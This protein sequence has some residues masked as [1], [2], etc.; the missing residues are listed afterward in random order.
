MADDYKSFYDKTGEGPRQNA[1]RAGRL[2]AGRKGGNVPYRVDRDGDAQ[3]GEGTSS[4]RLVVS[5]PEAAPAQNAVR[6]NAITSHVSRS[7]SISF[8]G[9]GVNMRLP[10]GDVFSRLGARSGRDGEPA[11]SA[12]TRRGR[13]VNVGDRPR[14]HHHR[15]SGGMSWFK[16]RLMNTGTLA[17]QWVK[18]QI[19]DNLSGQ[20]LDVQ[21]TLEGNAWVCYLPA[22][23]LVEQ[24]RRL[25]KKLN[26]P[27]GGK[28]AVNITP[29]H[30]PPQMQIDENVK[31][32]IKTVMASR[33]DMATESLNLS[34]F[35]EDP[36]FHKEGWSMGLWRVNVINA[37]IEL[38]I[39]NTPNLRSL[40]LSRNKIRDMQMW[41][42]LGGKIP[43]QRLNLSDNQIPRAHALEGL[44]ALKELR[45]LDLTRNLLRDEY[46]DMPL[47]VE[48]IR[49]R[50]GQLT[51]LDG[52]DLP[53]KIGFDAPVKTSLPTPLR[54]FV[55]N[56]ELRG[57]LEKFVKDFF[58][59]YDGGRQDLLHAYS[60]DAQFS[61]EYLR[62]PDRNHPY[63]PYNR[64]LQFTTDNST[65]I[66]RLVVGKTAIVNL[67]VSLPRTQHIVESFSM[68]IFFIENAITG[69]NLSGCFRE[70]FPAS[71]KGGTLRSFSRNFLVQS[72]LTGMSILSDTLGVTLAT[73][74]QSSQFA[75]VPVRAN[76]AL[77]PAVPQPTAA[78]IPDAAVQS[79]MVAQF[80]TQSGMNEQFS[81]MCLVDNGWDFDK[82]A[83]AFLLLHK[84]GKLP[85]EAFIK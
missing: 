58:F 61:L 44:K 50:L 59:C 33:Y 37:V 85:A 39:S 7:R 79:A 16:I 45:D 10:Q 64:N 77:P 19:Q 73:T 34:Y 18:K 63:Y 12:V 38:I 46:K 66:K 11:P 82:A 31:A 23:P 43:L 75:D 29:A 49:K 14:H 32:K 9:P 81:R 5:S 25:D 35:Y 21:M 15:V 2:W 22:G 70:D 17:V 27:H 74:E 6:R 78:G 51:R 65:R 24:I 60:D 76:Q 3:M 28:M 40:D 47:Y 20:P 41:A 80:A 8:T 83:G 55:P 52:V 30:G 68:D 36:V 26:L 69:F 72:S 4:T 71:A 84:E 48:S 56:E 54:I 53:K 13:G 62:S 57:P 42:K 1:L 67:F